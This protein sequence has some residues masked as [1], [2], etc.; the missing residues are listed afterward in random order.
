MKSTL[1]A[2]RDYPDFPEGSRTWDER[3]YHPDING[4][5]RPLTEIWPYGKPPRYMRM[6]IQFIRMLGSNPVSNSLRYA[7]NEQHELQFALGER[8]AV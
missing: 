7:W 6:I 8:E 5:V 2:V 1:D 4:V 3:V